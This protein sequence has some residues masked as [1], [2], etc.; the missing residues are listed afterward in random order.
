MT[1]LSSISGSGMT[2]H[3][4]MRQAMFNKMDSDGN[5][6]ISKD[7]FVN[8]RPKNVSEADAAKLYAKM[9]TDNSNALTQDQLDAG[10]EANKPDD[11]ASTGTALSS[12]MLS[13]L[14]N[15]LS[16]QGQHRTA[17]DETAEGGSSRSNDLFSKIDTDKDGKVTKEEFVNARPKNVSEE[18]AG[19]LFASIDTGNAG[20]VT[21]EQFEASMPKGG[22]GGPPPMGGLASSDDSDL[23]D[24][25]ESILNKY[26]YTKSTDSSTSE[27]DTASTTTSVNQTTALLQE[28]LNAVQSYKTTSNYGTY[29]QDL[30]TTSLFA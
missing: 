12:D 8:V 27:S 9:D 25:L 4:Q 16:G 30:L 29:T 15:L 17:Q 13:V 28:L 1:S 26:G 3:T 7:E 24:S 20:S 21:Q 10:M 2:H 14:I 19:K 22:P 5:G 11:A 18:D 23:E 6:N